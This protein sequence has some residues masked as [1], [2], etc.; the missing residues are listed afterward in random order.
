MITLF[1]WYLAGKNWQTGWFPHYC[2]SQPCIA[3]QTKPVPHIDFQKQYPTLL[4]TLDLPLKGHHSS[5]T[6][7]ISTDPIILVWRVRFVCMCWYIHITMPFLIW[8]PIVCFR[9]KTLLLGKSFLFNSSMVRKEL[10]D[11]AR[12][13]PILPYKFLIVYI[14]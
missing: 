4:I 10:S 2:W 5:I 11:N 1:L 13:M 14:R 7:Y 8:E 9:Y 6:M 12:L 3:L